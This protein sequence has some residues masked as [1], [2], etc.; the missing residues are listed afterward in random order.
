MLRNLAAEDTVRSTI[1][2]ALGY[3][4]EKDAGG[5]YLVP[6]L[7]QHLIS[8]LRDPDLCPKDMRSAVEEKVSRCCCR[9]RAA[10]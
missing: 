6:R 10:G 3:A 7:V 2:S 1:T 5:A 8:M 9:V 4:E